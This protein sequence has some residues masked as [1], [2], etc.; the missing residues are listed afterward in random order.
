[1]TNSLTDWDSSKKKR[2]KPETK[3]SGSK[4]E[5]K[6]GP[7][8]RTEAGK[9]SLQSYS[10]LYSESSVKVCYVITACIIK[11]GKHTMKIVA[12]IHWWKNPE[13]L[14]ESYVVLLNVL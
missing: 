9:H 1:M 11:N 5:G 13:T 7:M 4:L 6:R 3:G 8:S 2:K 10:I 14:K 12:A